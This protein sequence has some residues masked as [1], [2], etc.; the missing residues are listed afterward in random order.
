MNGVAVGQVH[1][2]GI[3]TDACRERKCIVAV[4]IIGI[5]HV[6]VGGRIVLVCRSEEDFQVVESALTTNPRIERD[7]DIRSIANSE[8]LLC[9]DD[10]ERTVNGI[11]GGGAIVRDEQCTL[12]TN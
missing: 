9:G 4:I 11:T 12:V 6:R 2:I 8:Q 1:H 10:R 3:R 5:I 7:N